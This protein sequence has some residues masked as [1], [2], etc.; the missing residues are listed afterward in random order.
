[1]RNNPFPNAAEPLMLMLRG[2]SMHPT[3]RA[4][5]AL[6]VKPADRVVPGDVVVYLCPRENSPIAHRVVS[7]GEIE[8]KTRGD[9]NASADLFPVRISDILGKV[10]HFERNGIRRKLQGGSYGRMQAFFVRA[11]KTATN[12]AVASFRS[13]YRMRCVSGICARLLPVKP[14]VVRFENSGKPQIQLLLGKRVI[15]EIDSEKRWHIKPP[16]R[17]FVRED[18]LPTPGE[19]A[20]RN[21]QI[22]PF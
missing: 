8:V 1:M 14:R 18:L 16:F 10:E 2:R 17:L 13:I 21:G 22:D 12:L 20:D 7:V 5:D 15:G 9:N 3:L 4:G 19:N 6:F 11:R